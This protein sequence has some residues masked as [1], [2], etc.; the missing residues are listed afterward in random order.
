MHFMALM[1]MGALCAALLPFTKNEALLLYLPP[2]LL[3]VAV[4]LWT[5]VRRGVLS[6]RDAWSAIGW[7]AGL[8]LILALPWLVFKWTHGL[9]FG[10]AK[11]FSTLGLA[12]QS[13]VLIAITVNTFFEGNWLLFFPLLIG[14]LIW[15][16]RAAFGR[17]SPLTAYVL[18]VCLGQWAIFLFTSLSVEAKMQTGLARGGVQLIPSMTLLCV[19]LLADAWPIIRPASLALGRSVGIV[20]A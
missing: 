20:R 15:R 6:K 2:L 17:W 19:L 13:G 18:I 7:Y 5:G 14:L 16:R 1:R 11:P 10:N 12:W 9:T 8:L 3:I 4:G